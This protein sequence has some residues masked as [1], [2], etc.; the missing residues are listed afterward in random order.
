MNIVWNSILYLIRHA[1]VILV[2][3]FHLLR[4]LCQQANIF[5]RKIVVHSGLE[6]A[7]SGLHS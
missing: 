3:G 1:S 7:T 6:P 5:G 2:V 4:R